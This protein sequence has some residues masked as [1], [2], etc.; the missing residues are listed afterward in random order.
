MKKK[1]LILL[2]I[3][4]V[5]LQGC[6]EPAQHDEKQALDPDTVD[7]LSAAI[8][9]YIED[10]QVLGD[11]LPLMVRYN[12]ALLDSVTF[13]ILDYDI[14]ERNATVKFTYVDALK[15][16]DSFKDPDISQDD[17]YAQSIDR[18]QSGD[19]A[20]VSQSITI[21]FEETV[22]GYVIQTS[23]DLVNVLSGGVLYY[24]LELLEDAGYG[25]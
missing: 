20:M 15:L 8:S 21:L 23:D 18:I 12:N 11:S 6:S 16:A 1:L 25:K 13:R 10:E 22:D 2:L 7:A 14:A 4:L 24:Y 17:Y 3:L 9:A 19:C 5:L